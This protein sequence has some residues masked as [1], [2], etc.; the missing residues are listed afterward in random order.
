M[1]KDFTIFVGTVGIGGAGSGEART[2][3]TLG[4]FPEAARTR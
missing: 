2:G 3:A 1:R 4:V